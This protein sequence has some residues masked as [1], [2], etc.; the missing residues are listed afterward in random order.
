MTDKKKKNKAD[1]KPQ[2][3]INLKMQGDKPA[4]KASLNDPKEWDRL[5]KSAFSKQVNKLEAYGDK[6]LDTDDDLPLA[7]HLQLFA[8]CAI[9]VVFI[10]WANLATLDEVTRGNGRV[11]PASDVQIIQH[12]EGGTIQALLVKEG[13]SVESGQVLMRLSDV[14]ASSDLGS[15]KARMT[16]L[17]AKIQRLQAEAE[18]K[19][20]PEFTDDVMEGAPESVRE[21][22]NTFRANKSQLDSQLSVLQSQAS[23]RRQEVSEINTRIADL[24][25]VISLTNEEMA[26]IQPLVARGSAPKRDVLQL[27]QQLAQQRSE[28]NGL[29]ASL[30]RANSAINEANARIEDL[31]TSFK[32]DAQNELT[33]TLVEAKTL[34]QQ[35]P[36]LQDRQT[37]TEIRSPVKGIVKDIKVQTDEGGGVIKPGD[38]VMEIV[39]V[40]D[41]L[42]VE[43]QIRPADIAFLHPEQPAIVKITAYDFS[44]YGGLKGKVTDISADTITNQEGES[45]YRVRVVT[46]KSTILRNG[47]ELPI[48]PGMVASVDILTG[49]KTVMEYLMKPLIKTLSQAMNER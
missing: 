26:M 1:T 41:Q 21:E 2:K 9:I 42:V 5:H 11:I 8:I 28:L 39:P 22:L 32:T 36:A 23:Q 10:I 47:S 44:I 29:R 6:L 17:Q 43:A 33:A 4:G 38:Q 13:D 15:T 34:Q 45:F 48:I 37:R 20:V 14:G 19:D 27:E 18:G 24:N 7:R 12:Q 49:E 25:R 16:G 46:E 40:D 3:T 35:I 30:P 31:K